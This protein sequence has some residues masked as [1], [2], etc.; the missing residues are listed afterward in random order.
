MNSVRLHIDTNSFLQLRDF[1]QIRWNDLFGSAEEVTLLVCQAVIAE[2]D[3][4]KNSTNKRR[5]DRAR[6]ALN[7]IEAAAKEPDMSLAIRSNAP[8]VTLT[9]WTG[10][11]NWADFPNLDSG[12]AD[13]YLVAAAGSDGPNAIVLSHD[14]GPRIR[15]RISGV[16]AES[17]L[18]DWLLPPE[19]TDDQR[20]MAQMQREL[21]ASK[22]ARPRLE[23]VLP[24]DDPLRIEA[25]SVPPLSPQL[26]SLLASHVTGEFPRKDLVARQG[27]PLFRSVLSDN[28]IGQTEID[29]YY[30]EYHGYES[31]VQTYF[32]LLN[33]KVASHA[34]AQNLP[35]AILNSGNVSARDL[36]LEIAVSGDLEI[37]ADREDASIYL[38][39]IEPP[40]APEPP[41]TRPV[42]PSLSPMVNYREPHRDPTGFYWLK[43]PKVVDAT[44][45]RLNCSDFRPG[46][47]YHSGVLFRAVGQLPSHGQLHIR[48]SAEHHEVVEA[49]REVVVESA[50]GLWLDP[51]VQEL[52]P[53]IV[54]Q[55]FQK[56]DAAKFPTW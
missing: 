19:Q 29:A 52:L 30:E 28:W 15:A 2:L 12:S 34:R 21:E 47:E 8:K 3:K 45:C 44:A 42:Y 11:P 32:A 48:V 36:T 53:D 35:W 46:R 33:E 9:I 51:G 10:K 50:F 14:T 24:P 22:N 26:A 6:K 49:H 13:D 1:N 20:K 5:R 56:I 27:N 55:A 4:H 43:R 41:R 18:D 7:Q 17:P 37:V 38:G 40:E 31:K 25:W 23:I 54:Q 39:S 16:R